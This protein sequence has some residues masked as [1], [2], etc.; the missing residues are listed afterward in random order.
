[1]FEWSKIF[2]END[3]EKAFYFL[4]FYKKKVDFVEKKGVCQAHQQ[5]VVISRINVDSASYVNWNI[6]AF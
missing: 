5:N 3:K 2:Q 6:V 4:K 1:M